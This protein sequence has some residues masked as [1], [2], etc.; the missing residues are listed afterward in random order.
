MPDVYAIRHLRRS[1]KIRVASLSDATDLV[2]GVYPDAYRE[3]SS[4]LKWSFWVVSPRG[5]L[6]VAKARI[7]RK[8]TDWW[9]WFDE[10]DDT[11]RTTRLL[12]AA[13]GYHTINIRSAKKVKNEDQ[14]GE[15]QST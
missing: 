2:R 9:L 8:S 6:L 3:G 11:M 1:E 5:P 14:H 12:T 4:G 10:D 7:L 15:H 13:H